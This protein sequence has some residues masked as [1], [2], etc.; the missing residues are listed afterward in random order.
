MESGIL[1]RVLKRAKRWHFVADK[2][3]KFLTC[4]SA[5]IP[6]RKD[7][8]RAP[9]PDE[10]LRLLRIAASRPEWQ[11]AYLASVL[12]FN[13]TMRGCE[14][15]QLRWRDVDLMD[16]TLTIQR[17][18]T[19]AGERIIPLNFDAYSAV[20]RLRERA[21]SL[22][23]S[24]RAPDWY[25]FPHSEGASK[26]MSSWRSAWWKITK[27]VY[28]AVCGALPDPAPFAAMRNAR[29]TSPKSGVPQ[30]GCASTICATTR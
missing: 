12:A 3:T 7:I 16:R 27:A 29:P 5:K 19:T 18:K 28:C 9:A 13:T 21:K 24:S 22:F 14:L 23:G 1:R 2:E 26:P 30:S 11:I 20:L 4:Q 25:V 17:S 15:K 6:E 8:A 10:K